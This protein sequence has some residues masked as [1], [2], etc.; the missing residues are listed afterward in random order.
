ML[1]LFQHL[2][3]FFLFSADAPFIPVHSGGVFRCN[4]MKTEFRGT[5]MDQK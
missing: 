4:L 1:N 2:I 3:S 5:H